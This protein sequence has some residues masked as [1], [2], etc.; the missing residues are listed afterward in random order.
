M[1]AVKRRRASAES[2]RLKGDGRNDDGQRELTMKLP[3]KVCREWRRIKTAVTPSAAER[4]VIS[5]LY[6]RI[7][8]LPLL[9]T[10]PA[11]YAVYVFVT[12]T[13]VVIDELRLR[14]YL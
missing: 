5:D 7:A 1:A 10:L 11:R 9:G 4:M 6:P 12:I 8:S 3:V 14:L 13:M 2:Y